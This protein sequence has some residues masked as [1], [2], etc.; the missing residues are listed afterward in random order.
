M[1]I[2]ISAQRPYLAHDTPYVASRLRRLNE[3]AANAD[4]ETTELEGLVVQVVDL[5]VQLNEALD[6]IYWQD[7]A[8]AVL[9]CLLR[10][11]ENACSA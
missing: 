2:A 7:A 6:T 5:H 3:A 4:A 11:K 8:I 9:N 1:A 10:D